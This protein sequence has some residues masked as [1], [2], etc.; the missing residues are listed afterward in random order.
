MNYSELAWPVIP[1]DIEAELLKFCVE[2]PEELS[3]QKKKFPKLENLEFFQFDAPEYLIKW[4]KEN[5]IEIND[6][7]TIQLQV[8]KNSDYGRRHIDMKRDYSY[9]YILM[10][11]PGITRWF[12]DD[13]TFIEEVKYEHK[14]WYKHVG[15]EK[16]HD[17]INVNNFRPAVT[18]YKRKE[19]GDTRPLFWKE[20]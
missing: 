18:I 11:H 16:Y 13:G 12:E 19:T 4:I 6:E 20:K 7:Y 3:I 1:H 14:K 9:N 17:V 15:S 10:D 8:W 5:L 2:C